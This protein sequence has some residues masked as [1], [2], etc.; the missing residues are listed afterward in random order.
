MSGLS[1]YTPVF[2]P[3][4]VNGLPL[5]G[6]V[7]K[8]FVSGTTT[9]APV[10]NDA[11]LTSPIGTSVTADSAGMFV[12]IY[13]DP[14]VIYKVALYDVNAVLQPHWPVDPLSPS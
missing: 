11:A 2:Q 7:L 3:L 10:Y 6:A 12:A 4:D 13:L 8:F 1:F 9:P 5:P 14:S